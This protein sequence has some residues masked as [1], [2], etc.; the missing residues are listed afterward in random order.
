M[1]QPINIKQ[2]QK[3]SNKMVSQSIPAQF[4]SK[5]NPPKTPVLSFMKP[6]SKILQELEKEDV[7]LPPSQPEDAIGI[8]VVKKGSY[9][10]MSMPARGGFMDGP[11]FGGGGGGM[12]SAFGGGGGGTGRRMNNALINNQKKFQQI[13]K[14]QEEKDDDSLEK[15]VKKMNLSTSLNIMQLLGGNNPLSTIKDN[16]EDDQ[17]T[18]ISSSQSTFTSKPFNKDDGGD[19][20]DQLPFGN[21]DDDDDDNYNNKNKNNKNNKFLNNKNINNNNNNDD[22]EF[23]EENEQQDDEEE[24]NND[25]LQFGDLDA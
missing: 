5:I 11:S 3:S 8:D 15:G 18:N 23:N 20:S 6:A 25:D 17:I 10:I 2:T 19:D 7:F 24:E 13:P 21:L 16:K 9:S 4:Y 12:G 22:E 14:K 1:A